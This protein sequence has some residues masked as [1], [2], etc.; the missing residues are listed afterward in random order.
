LDVIYSRRSIRSFA[1]TKLDRTTVTGLLDAAVQAPTAMIEEPWLFV[2]VQDAALLRRLSDRVK[3]DWDA[4]AHEPIGRALDNV[5]HELRKR[6]AVPDFSIFYDATTLVVIC[7][8][9]SGQFAAADCWLAAENLML[10]A[11]AL[12]LGTCCIGTALSTLNT[13]EWKAELGMLADVTA[14]APIIIGVPSGIAVPVPRRDPVI[15]SWT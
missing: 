10:A 14:I 11:C 6:L 2:V 15:L 1:P 5:E 13:P 9:H 4:H 7:T 3:A 8:R 12:G